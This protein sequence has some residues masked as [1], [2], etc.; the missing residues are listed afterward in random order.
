MKILA[1]VTLSVL[2]FL[3]NLSSQSQ[4]LK[5]LNHV[6]T[7]HHH[8]HH[9]HH[10]HGHESKQKKDHHHHDAELA[11]LNTTLG[12]TNHFSSFEITVSPLDS[13]QSFLVVNQSGLVSFSSSIFRPPI[14]S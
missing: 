6:A 3:G 5:L 4:S 8:D 7:V 11:S 12:V 2:F 9:V 14:L 10:S 13:K 1:L